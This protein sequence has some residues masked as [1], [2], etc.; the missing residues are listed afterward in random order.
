M[1]DW[2]ELKDLQEEILGLRRQVLWD[3]LLSELKG[4]CHIVTNLSQATSELWLG[5]PVPDELVGS[6]RCCLVAIKAP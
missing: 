4:Q 1:N 2:T 3:A 5:A 6:G